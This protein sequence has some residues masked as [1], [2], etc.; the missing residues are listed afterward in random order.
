L[1][2]QSPDKEKGDDTRFN[3]KMGLR[4]FARSLIAGFHS[5]AIIHGRPLPSMAWLATRNTIRGRGV[6]FHAGYPK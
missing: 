1:H 4:L 5:K 6:P 2:P 3:I